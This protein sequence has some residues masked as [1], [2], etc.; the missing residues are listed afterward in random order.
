MNEIM[1]H[2]IFAQVLGAG[3][4]HE[5]W[6]GPNGT[7]HVIRVQPVRAAAVRPVVAPSGRL[8]L[9][10]LAKGGVA[11]INGGYFDPQT[12][13]A[14]SY[15]VQDGRIVSDP[16]LNRRLMDNPSLRPY[17]GAIGA[18][19]EWRLLSGNAG[20]RW[21]LAPHGSDMPV[22]WTLRHALQ[23]GPRLLP[24]DTSTLEAF[25]RPGRD[26]INAGGSSAR[27][28]LGLTKAGELLL[29]MSPDGQPLAD[30]GRS[31]RQ[32]GCVEAMALDGGSS[33]QLAW[34]DATGWHVV[35]PAG[36][37]PGADGSL[38][39]LVSALVVGDL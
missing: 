36:R 3:V 31:L 32:M 24:D 14:V 6:N 17:L 7:L 18:R 19:T 34:H 23:A 29:V 12:A 15:V 9:T 28:G 30:F 8:A 20:C 16:T 37:K 10:A 27:S 22:G 1:L 4:A 33:S 26:A 21:Q 39:G 38:V 25:L 35:G 2:L 11:A 5:T 13:G